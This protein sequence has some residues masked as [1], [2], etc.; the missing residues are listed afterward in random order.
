MK[1]N[2]YL[3]LSA[4]ALLLLGS[5][6]DIIQPDIGKKQVN[7]LAPG[8]QYTSKN[9]TI[10]FWWDEIENASAYR[11]QIVTP[12]FDSIGAL[13]ADTLVQ[14]NKFAFN[15][16][17]GSYQWRVRAENSGSQGIFSAP[18]GFSVL[19]SSIKQQAVQLSAPSADA[20]VNTPD[21]TFQW[22]TVYGATQYRL[23]IDTNNFA[24]TARLLYNKTFPVQEA[25]FS[26]PKD[27]QYQWRIRAENDTAQSKWS[28]VRVL[29]YD[30]TPPGQ[31][32]LIAP[33]DAKVLPL[34]VSLQW[35]AV[36]G[37][38]RYKL[39]VLKSDSTSTYNPTFPM[40]LNTNSYNFNLGNSG[41][42]IYWKVSALDAAGN[43][44]QVSK[45]QSFV[46]Q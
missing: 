12:N 44:G 38:S 41:D 32:T 26:L 19:F 10:N 22:G 42:R 2:L 13:I 3:L 20:L 18:R 11:L 14:S 40:L 36:T 37:A 1:I 46:L 39:Y 16:E 30:H 29:R 28:A 25:K 31:V 21:I 4:A 15:L 23:E 8:D 45:L 34:P 24:D 43:E 6:K 35:N 33:A 5:C 9:Y 27:Q 17:P 7:L